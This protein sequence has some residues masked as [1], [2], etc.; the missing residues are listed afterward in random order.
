MKKRK[1][2]KEKE[3]TKNDEGHLSDSEDF[4]SL[5]PDEQ[6]KVR[7]ILRQMKNKS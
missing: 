1:E 7:N 5:S 3:K 6:I 4:K 2:K